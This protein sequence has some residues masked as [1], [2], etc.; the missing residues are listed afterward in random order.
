MDEVEVAG[1]AEDDVEVA[2]EVAVADEVAVGKAVVAR[3][4]EEAASECQGMGGQ[5]TEDDSQG[6]GVAAEGHAGCGVGFGDG[7]G[8]GRLRRPALRVFCG[9]R[10]DGGQ[11]G[12]GVETA[13]EAAEQGFV[14]GGET[15]DLAQAGVGVEEAR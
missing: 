7:C 6:E 2:G 12:L 11:A 13:R 9:R 3:P 10:Q 14:S 4:R 15:S 8:W 5:V 1:E